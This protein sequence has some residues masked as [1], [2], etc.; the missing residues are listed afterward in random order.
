MRL[1]AALLAL[2]L[3]ATCSPADGRALAPLQLPANGTG[4]ATAT[5]LSTAAPAPAPPTPS[6]PGPP[7][8]ANDRPLIGILT[9]ACHSCPGRCV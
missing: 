4:A 1:P 8:V 9:Q 2:A 3:L 5:S 7:P 6:P